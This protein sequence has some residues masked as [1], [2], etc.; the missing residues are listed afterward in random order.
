MA[1]DSVKGHPVVSRDEWLAARTAFLV[2]EKE[3]TRLRDDLC[4]QRR[5]LPWVKVEK[6]YVYD[7]PSGKESL[8]DLFEKRSQLVVYHFMFSP[9]WDQGCKH[10]SFWADHFD[11]ARVHLKHRDVVLVVISRAPLAKI[12]PF[13]KRMGWTF[14]WVSSFGNEFNYDFGAS[15]TPEAIKSGSVFY[16]YTKT[17]MNRADREGASVFYK[18]PSGQIF[19]TYSC[20]ARGIDNLNGTY[21]FLDFVPKGRDEDSF[22]FSQAWVQYHDCYK[23]E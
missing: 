17:N 16:N 8:A 14:K 4:R 10:C 5:A 15:F 21:H 12:E 19:H 23:D 9:E 13:K 3:F 6:S 22:E 1:T 2:K 11:A 7:G 18:D 20:Y